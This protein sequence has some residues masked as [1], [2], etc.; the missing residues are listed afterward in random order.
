VSLLI[1]IA[2]P[3]YATQDRTTIAVTIQL[4]AV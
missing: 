4:R 1:T 2:E 3:K